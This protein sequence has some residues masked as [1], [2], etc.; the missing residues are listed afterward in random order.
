[1]FSYGQVTLD[2][3]GT[4]TLVVDAD[5]ELPTSVQIFATYFATA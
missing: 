2:S 5:P 3:S 1:M 4:A